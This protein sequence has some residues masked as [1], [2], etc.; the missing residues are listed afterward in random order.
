M[1]A[2]RASFLSGIFNSRNIQGNIQV[3]FSLKTGLITRLTSFCR[4]FCS[5]E[6]CCSDAQL[7]FDSCVFLWNN[8]N[9][10]LCIATTEYLL[11]F[12]YTIDLVKW[13]FYPVCQKR[14]NHRSTCFRLTETK[15]GMICLFFK[16]RKV[17]SMLPC[18]SSVTNHRRWLS[19]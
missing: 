8:Q 18:V 4:I 17:D 16:W 15:F 2:A 5:F 14:A 19:S 1:S 6:F 9:S 7:K 11:Q 12:V 13:L 3:Y 10:W